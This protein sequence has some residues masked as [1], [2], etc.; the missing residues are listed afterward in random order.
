MKTAKF[1]RKGES[2]KFIP[3]FNYKGYLTSSVQI[4]VGEA[5]TKGGFTEDGDGET[6]EEYKS[7]KEKYRAYFDNNSMDI[8]TRDFV[9]NNIA[10]KDLRDVIGTEYEKYL[11]IFGTTANYTV[12]DVEEEK[13]NKE[14]EEAKGVA[15]KTIPIKVIEGSFGKRI[16]TRLP[17]DIF[18]KIKHEAKYWSASEIDDWN[19]DMDDF[20]KVCDGKYDKGWYYTDKAIEILKN[21]GFEII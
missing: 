19:E 4:G 1:T 18:A 12:V 8:S 21:L 5:T 13:A 16:V 17:A 9:K 2:P 11:I 7:Y 6:W 14:A 20:S 3:G 10:N 15:N